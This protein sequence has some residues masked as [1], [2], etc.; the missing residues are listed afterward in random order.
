LAQRSDTRSTLRRMRRFALIVWMAALCL[1]GCAARGPLPM[2][3]PGD[4]LS[5]VLATPGA[6]AIQASGSIQVTSAEG[7]YTGGLLLYYREPDSIKVMVQVGFGTTIAEMVMTGATGI[8]YLPQQRQALRIDAGSALVI[9]S[10]TVYPALL[11]RLMEPVSANHLYRDSL[12]LIVGPTS[13]YLR[14]VSP[15][16]VRTWQIGGRSGDLQSEEFASA[17]STV[18][19]HRA[20]AVQ[21]NQRVPNY[22]SVQFGD[23]VMTVHLNRID[24]APQWRRTPFT[25]RLPEGM[26]PLPATLY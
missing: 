10:A 24:V 22:F 15:G 12:E 11:A 26:E 25:V 9:G 13:Y 20:F 16:G 5:R 3:P 7:V 19:W 6:R 1:S 4:L 21:R 14:D 23:A 2:V 17:E 8:A 18:K